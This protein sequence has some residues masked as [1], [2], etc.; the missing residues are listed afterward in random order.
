M[1]RAAKKL[2]KRYVEGMDILDS[3]IEMSLLLGYGLLGTDI[4]LRTLD[5]WRRLWD[6]W[7]DTVMPKA[8]E[9]RPGLRPFACYVC[10]ELPERPVLVEPPLSNGYFRLYVPARGGT[11][12]WHY[13]YPEPYQ[14]S[15]A[16]HLFE[17][18]V[19][20]K[21][22]MKRHRAWIRK[23]NPGPCGYPFKAY[24]YEQGLYQ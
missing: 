4:H 6:R 11:G 14:R 23:V 15:E 13:R 20:D 18:G 10:G 12:T 5:D 3:E 8:I 19:I 9:A 16:A 17:L 7:R 24:S 1:P 2:L 21:E 22:E